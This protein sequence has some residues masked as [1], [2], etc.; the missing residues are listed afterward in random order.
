MGLTLIPVGKR[1][2]YTNWL[3]SGH[4][5]SKRMV[6]ICF[7]H[8][9]EDWSTVHGQHLKENQKEWML[10]QQDQMSTTADISD[11]SEETQY[12][13]LSINFGTGKEGTKY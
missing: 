11:S 5:G 7:N 12:G 8:M 9:D 2:E 13:S 3:I 1:I 10:C 6:L 4:M